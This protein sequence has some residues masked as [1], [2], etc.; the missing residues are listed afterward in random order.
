MLLWSMS[1]VP[2]RVYAIV[3][4]FNILL[5]IGPQSFSLLCLARSGLTVSAGVAVQLVA[6]C[7]C[8][9]IV[10]LETIREVR[11]LRPQRSQREY[12]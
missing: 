2:F 8:R 11:I 7:T 4:Y 6:V 1:G 10:L 9:R 5:Q 3:Q 12:R